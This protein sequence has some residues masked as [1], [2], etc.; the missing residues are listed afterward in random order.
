MEL[1]VRRPTQQE[2]SRPRRIRGQ[3]RRQ[4]QQ[5]QQESQEVEGQEGQEGQEGNDSPLDLEK[6]WKHLQKT[7]MRGRDKS[8]KELARDFRA[9]IRSFCLRGP[10]H[11]H[12]VEG[13]GDSNGDNNGNCEKQ[14]HRN[15]GQEEE[16]EEEERHLQECNDGE[17]SVEVQGGGDD[18]EDGDDDSSELLDGVE[19][20][21]EDMVNQRQGRGEPE[22]ISPPGTF[23]FAPWA[24]TYLP[25][26]L[27]HDCI[28]AELPF[29]QR[30]KRPDRGKTMMLQV[31]KVLS[32]TWP[33]PQLSPPPQQRQL[34]RGRGRPRRSQPA[35][36][37]GRSRGK[38]GQGCG[39]GR[40]RVRLLDHIDSLDEEAYVDEEAT[41]ESH[42]FNILALFFG[43]S[44]FSSRRFWHVLK[45]L[46]PG[47]D[48]IF[49]IY[50]AT[51]K[52]GLGRVHREQQLQLQQRHHPFSVDEVQGPSSPAPVTSVVC[53][54]DPE[55]D[56]PLVRPRRL[57][58][59]PGDLPTTAIIGVCPPV[60]TSTSRALLRE[61]FICLVFSFLFFIS[62]LL[63]YLQVYYT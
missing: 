32:E 58:L 24:M 48:S 18:D 44:T 43:T 47:R 57:V 31:A 54:L 4:E 56:S 39:Q 60:P 6:S 36:T 5:D 35:K 41:S 33:A 38:L 59:Q 34:K 28:E 49:A 19:D 14:E 42:M 22:E 26:A 37:D 21:A 45:T 29:K 25:R 15:H 61:T 51:L 46:N 3:Q 10:G 1:R 53:C 12:V 9:L 7:W 55:S 40:R 27:L 2:A 62:Y 23:L 17:T 20:D 52:A 16:G 11:D 50:H 63:S 8:R 30:I 13:H